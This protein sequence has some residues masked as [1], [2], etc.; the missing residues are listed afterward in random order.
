M[1]CRGVALALCG[2][3]VLGL[4]G[5]GTSSKTGA[6]TTTIPTTGTTVRAATTS[7]ADQAVAGTTST[8]PAASDSPVQTSTTRASK[9]GATTTV[10]GRV[11]TKPNDNVHLGDTGPGVKQ[12][13]T[14]LAAQ[15]YKVAADGNFGTQTEQA[16]K[17]FQ[18]KNGLKQ[19]GVVGPST[20]AKLQ[21]APTGMTTKPATPT[22]VKRTTTTY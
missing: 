11:V 5:C 15:G 12:I 1:S 10:A 17:D 13:Q 20:W 2:A 3:T 16:V 7:T 6:G 8:S 19:D 14:R 4:V 18:S 22:T 21:A 9:S